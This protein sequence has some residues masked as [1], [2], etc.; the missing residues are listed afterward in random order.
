MALQRT[1]E[2][3]KLGERINDDMYRSTFRRPRP[4]GRFVPAEKVLRVPPLT[5]V[6]RSL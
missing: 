4:I 6:P 3:L 5:F 2:M 1:L